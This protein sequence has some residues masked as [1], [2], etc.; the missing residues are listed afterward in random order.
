MASEEVVKKD[1][2][3]ADKL[4]MDEFMR[5]VVAQMF[6][7]DNDLATLEVVLNDTGA[8]TPPELKLEIKLVSINGVATREH[9]NDE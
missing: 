7:N 9:G 8:G 3:L 5:V 2:G 4:T 6:E 1:L